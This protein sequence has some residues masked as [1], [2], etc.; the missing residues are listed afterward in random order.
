ME[1]S[2]RGESSGSQGE[3]ITVCVEPNMASVEQECE[4]IEARST[5]T[6]VQGESRYGEV[7]VRRGKQREGNA[8]I[9]YVPSTLP[10]P[11]PTPET[12]APHDSQSEHTGDVVPLSPLS[13]PISL[14]KLRER[15]LEFLPIDMGSRTILVTLYHTHHCHRNME[16]SLHH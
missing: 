12:P 10:Q 3:P 15:M 7:Y 14:R 13:L 9:P 2:C 4:R 11:N 5:G 16:H 6:Q 8:M 1:A